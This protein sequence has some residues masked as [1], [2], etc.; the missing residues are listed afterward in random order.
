M[1]VSG[2]SASRASSSIFIYGLAILHLL[3]CIQ[4]LRTQAHMTPKPVQFHHPHCS[5]KGVVC[6]LV[7]YTLVYRAGYTLKQVIGCLSFQS[8]Q[9]VYFLLWMLSVIDTSIHINLVLGNSLEKAMAPHSSTLAWKSHGQRSLVGCSPWGCEESD[10]TERLHFHFSLSCIGEGNGIPLQCSWLENPRDG[11]AWWA[12]VYGVTQSRTQL[13]RLSSSSREFLVLFSMLNICIYPENSPVPIFYFWCYSRTRPQ[14]PS[15]SL[16]KTWIR[17]R[18]TM[19][20]Y[21]RKTKWELLPQS[22]PSVIALLLPGF[23]KD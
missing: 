11:G 23:G 13:K 3:I 7:T 14:R 5:A 6:S 12:A 2:I 21:W 17:T 1:A 20:T 4:S 9:W 16:E 15:G 10:T 8:L 22:L 18:N 19:T